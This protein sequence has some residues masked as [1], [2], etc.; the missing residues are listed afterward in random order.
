MPG[1]V[2]EGLVEGRFPKTAA[3][4]P[5]YHAGPRSFHKDARSQGDGKQDWAGLGRTGQDRLYRRRRI[6]AA[7][8]SKTSGTPHGPGVPPTA[9]PPVSCAGGR[10]PWAG[11]GAPASVQELAPSAMFTRSP[12]SGSGWAGL[13]FTA[14]GSKSTICGGTTNLTDATWASVHGGYKNKA[15]KTTSTM[16]GGHSNTASGL[17]STVAGGMYGTAS[18]TSAMVSGGYVSRASG[19]ASTVNG[20]NRLTATSTYAVSCGT[21]AP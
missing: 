4:S 12:Q 3:W 6:R 10:A 14:K 18:G 1:T 8:S 5:R 20:G 9:H 21:N 19:D 11:G 7:S 15:T 17:W 13:P 2:R 16:L